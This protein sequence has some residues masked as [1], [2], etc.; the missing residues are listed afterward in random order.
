LR[1]RSHLIVLVGAAVLPL[2][3]FAVLIVRQDVGERREIM[4]RGMQDTVRARSL[5][6]DGE[7]K[8]SLAVLQ[9]L[10]ASPFLDR[11]DLAHFHEVC[12]RAMRDRPDAYVVLFDPTGKVLLN[13]GRPFGAPLPNPLT[14]TRPAGADPRYPDVPLGGGDPV[15]NVLESGAPV[16]SDLFISLVTRAPRISLDVPVVRAGELRYVLEMSIDATQLTRVLEAQRP[17]ADAVLSLVDR[18]GIVIARTRDAPGRVGKAIGS[19]FAQ[20]ISAS[21]VGSDVGHSSKGTPV[22]R[23]HAR[24]PLSGWTTSLGVAKSVALAPLSNTLALLAGGAAIAIVLGLA[25]ALLIGRRISAPISA[26][27]A[28]AGKLA[29]GEQDEL[30][31]HAVRELEDLHR[32][33]VAA[34][35]SAR[36]VDEVQAASRAKDEFL[37]MLS[38]ELR[39]PLAALTAAAHVLKIANPASDEAMKAAAV[40][41]RQT[42]HMSR[43]IS[44]LLDISRITHGKFAL[45]RER[46]DLAEAVTRLVSVWRVWGRFERHNV[47]LHTAA[48]WIDA[49]RARIDQITANLLDNALKF[50]PA[51]K[52]VHLTVEPGQGVA[53]LRIA[54]EGLGL[55]PE[56]RQ[57]IFELFVQE[58]PAADGGLGIGLALVKRLAEIHGGTAAVESAGPGKGAMFTVQLPS[59]PA[60]AAAPLPVSSHRGA[61]RTV[62]IVEDNDD[63]R[64]MLVAALTLDG[65]QV[66]A[67]PD[68]ESGLQLAER[69]PP[70]VALIDIRLPGIDG[71]EVARRLRAANER[72]RIT[73]VAL[74]G[75]GQTED[76]RRAFDAG[77]DAHLVKPVNA[78][79][80]KRVLAELQ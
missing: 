24:S 60:P 57:R 6:I 25:A 18:R 61:C 66:H 68:G 37:A 52:T 48:V 31:V 44:D 33:L 27:A 53:L 26:L 42:R 16:V 32:A 47:A 69:S 8:T 7:V 14:A 13:S 63:A 4:D 23:V 49:D 17:P 9:T 41:E 30:E 67:A 73:L 75:F 12:T 36:Q 76:R 74:T 46:F 10:A 29:R 70:D 38:H 34:G 51:G 55:A 80:L 64:H 78:E 28:A 54:D 56:A 1:L 20:Q 21:D 71:Y 59:V 3:L 22:Y 58:G 11:G 35:V 50:T 43:L 45:D 62:L 65:H 2:L 79:R 15:K 39:N 72:R 40:V 77:F 5:A 19:E